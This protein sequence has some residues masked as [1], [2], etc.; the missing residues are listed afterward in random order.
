MGNFQYGL[1]KHELKKIIKN[2]LN[3]ICD[4]KCKVKHDGQ[5]PDPKGQCENRNWWEKLENSQE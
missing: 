2:H 3:R 4:N 1:D 5:C